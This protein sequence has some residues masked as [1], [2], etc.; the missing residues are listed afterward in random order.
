MRKRMEEI[1]ERE[2]EFNKK[3]LFFED[4]E[5]F[6]KQEN[7]RI[8][9]FQ[10]ELVKYRKKIIQLKKELNEFKLK[11]ISNNKNQLKSYKTPTLIGLDNI[12]AICF[13]NSSLQCLSQT[14]PLTKYF[15]NQENKVKIF[16]NNLS[17]NINSD[18]LS[19]CYFELIQ[20][21]WNQN[22]SNKSYNPNDF[23][24][25]VNDMNSLFK[26]GE[27]GD[28]K[29]FIIFILEQIHKELKSKIK[30]DINNNSNEKGNKI[31]KEL[32]Q[33]DR[34]STLQNFF[35]DFKNECSIISD[36]FFGFIE[37]TNE[38]QKCKFDFSIK[39]IANPICYNYQI[40]NCLIFPLEEVK[41]LKN[42]LINN[43]NNNIVTLYDCFCY[44]QQSNLFTGENRN[45]CNIC[46]K[47]SDSLYTTKIYSAPNILIII[48]NRGK[49]NIYNIKLDFN[50]VIDLTQFIV[51]KDMPLIIYSLYGV[52]THIGESG[53]NAH[54]VASCKSP[55]DSKWYR[56]NDSIVNHIKDIKKEII[57]FGTPYILFY[58]KNKIK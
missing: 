22:N 27:A 37:T 5:L 34:E 52:I 46:K 40:F 53:P 12:G 16:N 39:N 48:L 51:M 10:E 31:Q 25:K 23:I 21:L 19:P 20:N 35:N 17:K 9:K 14:K 11:N 32:N 47:L 58:Q 43:I 7:E 55:I 36:I 6:L 50:E 2:N 24:K 1:I 8:E 4:K 44:Y 29:D 38:C 41:N 18:Q 57:D 42:N 3:L 45:Y 15:L 33:Y 26:K 28:S 49:N 13:I 30:Y 54:F 56:Y